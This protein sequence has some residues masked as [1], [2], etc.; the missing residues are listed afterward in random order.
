MSDK[1]YDRE[2]RRRELRSL[3][4]THN[5][6]LHDAWSIAIILAEKFEGM[7][8]MTGPRVVLHVKH[9]PRPKKVKS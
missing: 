7:V 6:N 1:V 3:I 9:Q 5:L 2:A 8:K 4:D